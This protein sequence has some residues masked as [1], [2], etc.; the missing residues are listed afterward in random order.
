MRVNEHRDQDHA[1]N[2]YRGPT[3]AIEST[4]QK[5]RVAAFRGGISTD[6]R[7]VIGTLEFRF[8][9]SEKREGREYA[10]V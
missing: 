9:R 7:V 2:S 6:T 4:V 8:P 5:R 10:E 3:S 1:Q